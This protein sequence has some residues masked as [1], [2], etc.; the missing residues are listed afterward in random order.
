MKADRTIADL[1]RPDSSDIE[2]ILALN[3]LIYGPHDILVNRDDFNWRYRLNPAGE[4]IVPVIRNEAGEVVGFIWVVPIRMHVRGREWLMAMGTNLVIHPDYQRTFGYVK[5]LRRFEKVF[6][7][8]KIPLHFSFVS[9]DKYQQLQLLNPRQ[10]ITIP[11][12]IKP[13]DLKE[14]TQRFFTADWQRFISRS[15]DW[16]VSP[17]LSRNV[18]VKSEPDWNVQ[19]LDHFTPAFDTFWQQVRDKYPVAVIRDQQFLNWRFAPVSNRIYRIVVAE[20]Q[21]KMVGYAVLH[22]HAIRNVKTGLILDLLVEESPIGLKAGFHLLAT[23]EAYFEAERVAMIAGLMVSA[24]HEYQ[25]LRQAGY[26]VVPAAILPRI[27]RYAFFLHGK[28]PPLGL[29]ASL[30]YEWFI[31]LADYESY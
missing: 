17:L 25:L 6:L 2:Q 14:L 3:R 29:G 23:A 15:A 11:L 10:A 12:L 22:C 9:E 20:H 26:R 30:P 5:L 4:A 24:A 13:F 31:T 21:G 8:H 16:L 27:F 28:T 1:A 18:S 7:E 19:T